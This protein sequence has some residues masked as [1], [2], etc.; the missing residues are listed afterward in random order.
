MTASVVGPESFLTLHYR[1]A[2]F[3]GADIINTFSGKPSTLGMGSGELSPALEQVL[4]GLPEGTRKEFRLNAGEAFGERNPELVQWVAR[5]LLKE[6]GDHHEDYSEG[7][8]VQFPMPDGIG[9]YAGMVR[10]VSD[11]AVKFDFNHPLAGQ[12]VIFEVELIGVL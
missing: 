6:L 11:S 10:E 1:L 4:I 9:T 5:K 3:D 7:D 8:V 2:G 12:P